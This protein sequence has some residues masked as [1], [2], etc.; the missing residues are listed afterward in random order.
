MAFRGIFQFNSEEIVDAQLSGCQALSLR[1][2]AQAMRRSHSDSSLAGWHDCRDKD[3][4]CML[5]PLDSHSFDGE[6]DRLIYISL[7]RT[8]PV[9]GTIISTNS[10]VIY[11]HLSFHEFL[12]HS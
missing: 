5:G 3:C 2:R 10:R 12:I 6:N 8:C 7:E 9:C 1:P 11:A 4:S